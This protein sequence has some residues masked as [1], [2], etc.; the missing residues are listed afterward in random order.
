MNGK[1]NLNVVQVR[2][3]IDSIPNSECESEYMNDKKSE[4]EH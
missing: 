3:E 1:Q 4:C 2:N